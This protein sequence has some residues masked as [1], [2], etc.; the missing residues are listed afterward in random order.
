MPNPY[1]PPEPKSRNVG[2]WV[3]MALAILVVVLVVRLAA[4]SIWTGRAPPEPGSPV[5]VP[6]G[7]RLP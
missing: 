3:L 6:I 4:P 7:P 5:S 2:W 1:P